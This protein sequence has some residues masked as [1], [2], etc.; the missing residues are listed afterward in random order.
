[1]VFCM[2]CGQELPSDAIFCHKCGD[3]VKEVTEAE[4]RDVTRTGSDWK[5]DLENAVGTAVRS[6]E[7]GLQ[8]AF[9][10]I[11]EVRWGK[12]RFR[13]EEDRSFSG[14]VQ[15]ERVSFSVENV[16]GPV[17][18]STWEKSEYNMDLIIKA[19][20]YTREEADEK[21]D[22]IKTNLLDRVVDRQRRLILDIERPNDTRGGYSVELDVTLPSNAE[23]DLDLGSSN[24]LIKASDVKGR[25]L[26]MK[27]SNGMLAMKNVSMERVS[28]RTSNGRIT[29]ALVSAEDIDCRSSNGRI[30]GSVDTVNA[31]MKTSNGKV[32]LDLKCTRSGEYEL[33]TSNGGIKVK[34]SG[35]PE[36]GYDLDLNTS[37]SRISADLPELIY[38]RDGRNTKMMKTAGYEEK[39][40]Q[41]AINADTSMGRIKVS[42]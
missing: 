11:G 17:R 24:G 8:T 33:Q 38:T 26:K 25:T 20:G 5:G 21:L 1:M 12:D 4:A 35:S 15:E 22:R 3:R 7:D 28:G 23:I 42:P 6:V 39:K 37:M 19:W 41:I 9:E 18:V 31:Y 36:V 10:S 27:T 29:L 32:D 13:V 16:N 30:E 34:V 14:D 2:K 40:V